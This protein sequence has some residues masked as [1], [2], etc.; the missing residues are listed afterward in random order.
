MTTRQICI[1]AKGSFN[2]TNNPAGGPD[3]AAETTLYTVINH[4][5]AVPSAPLIT[6][7]NVAGNLVVSWPADAGTFT[8]QSTAKIAPTSWSPVT[9]QPPTVQVGNNFQMT[10]PISAGNVYFRLA[11]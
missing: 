11:R 7:A 10:M 6:V 9:P 4:P 5:G 3:T 1:A 2:S 8:L